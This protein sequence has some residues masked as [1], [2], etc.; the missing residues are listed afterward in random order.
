MFGT[1]LHTEL[2]TR[3][4]QC[5]EK[6]HHISIFIGGIV[7]HMFQSLVVSMND[8]TFIAHLCCPGMYAGHNGKELDERDWLS[9]PCCWPFTKKPVRAKYGPIARRFCCICEYVQAFYWDPKTVLEN[10]FHIE[11]RK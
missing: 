4:Y 6:C 9:F 10:G 2:H 8:N 1:Y 11:C 7:N 3:D 5:P